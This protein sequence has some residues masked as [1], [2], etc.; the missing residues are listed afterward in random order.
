MSMRPA[1]TLL[2]FLAIACAAHAQPTRWQQRVQYQMQIDMDVKTHRYEGVQRLIYYNNSPD[3]LTRLFYHLYLNAFKPGSMMETRSRLIEDPDRRVAQRIAKLKPEEQGFIQVSK[4]THNGEDQ[5]FYAN[6]TILEVNLKRPI[7][8]GSVDTLYMEW[9]A[10][11]PLQIRRN[12][13]NNS[14]GIDYSMAQ[15]YPKLCEYDEQ[16]WH[17]NPYI[18]REFYGVWG[19]FDVSI[20]IDR[21]YAVAAGGYL[22]N[23]NEVATATKLSPGSTTP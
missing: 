4:L 6:E 23:P 18:G 11:I 5:P 19:D 16:G 22:Q 15:W 13:R 12:G 9:T 7:L 8:P 10:Q 17:A 1:C 20:S 21:N 14:E 2:L 3:T